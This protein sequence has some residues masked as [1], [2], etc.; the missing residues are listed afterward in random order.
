MLQKLNERIQGLVAWIVIILI[1][2]TFTLFGVDYYMQSRQSSTAEVEVNGEAISKQAYEINY[3]RARQQRDA[4][5]MTAAG[6]KALKKQVLDDMIVN[7]VTVQAA[8]NNGFAV[9]AEQANAAILQIPQ[10]QEDGHFSAERYQQALSGAM[11]TPESFQKEVQQGMLLNQ[12][13]FAFIGSAFALP[14]EI[15][16]FVKLYMQTRDYDYLE[17]PAALFSKNISIS[18]E[19]INQYYQDHKKEFIA[20]EQVSIDY[21]RL[22]MQGLR[23]NLTVSDDDV[24]RYYDENK[25]NFQTPAQWQVAHILFAIP[26][27]ASAE[28]EQQ[29]KQKAED[30]YQTLQKNP[31]QFNELV[32]TM[33]DDKLSQVNN[34]VLPWLTAGQTPFS[35]A[36]ADL[37][38]PGQI[39]TPIQSAHGY[40]IFKVMNYKPATLKPLAEVQPLIKEQLLNEVAQNKYSEALEQLSDISYQ[41]PDSLDPVADA[42]KLKVEHS[43]AFS[44]Q[45]GADDLTKNKDVI[46]AAFSHDVLELGNNSEPVQLDNDSVI[47]LRVNKHIPAAQKSLAEVK[48]FIAKV[49]TSKEAEKQAKDFGQNFLSGNHDAEE[50]LL[51]EKQL[52][53]QN[54]EQATRDTDKANTA[55]NN[56]A[57]SLAKTNNRSGRSLRNGDYVVVRLRKINDGQYDQLD[58]EQQASIAQQIESSYGVMDYDL[59]VNS[60]LNKAKIDKHSS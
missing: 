20:P 1:A 30:A 56:L 60:L 59:Y 34:G 49:L 11:F 2:V 19:S 57:F 54:I 39:S 16:R 17:I 22:S 48:D 38:E 41:S 42:L 9:S 8:K 28:V 53:W 29:I 52:H 51:A 5:Q 36:L 44:R 15:Q 21:V 23:H 10:F 14:N 12:Q 4:A 33:S 3:R 13:R 43:Q 40:E 46:N 26:E 32:K 6:E 58:K 25:D 7:T 24:K 47:V 45:G 31:E 37:T 27:D 50:K 55:V 18:D 35:K